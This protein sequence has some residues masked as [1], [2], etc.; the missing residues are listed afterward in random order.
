MDHSLAGTEVT[1]NLKK[2]V[3]NTSEAAAWR[4]CNDSR[5]RQ[6]ILEGTLKAAKGPHGWRIRLAD[7][8]RISELKRRG[9]KP[10]VSYCMRCGKKCPSR[11][12]AGEHCRISG[13]F[14]GAI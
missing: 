7:L 4:G 2:I 11:M 12:A 9:P 10:M 5:I 3:F 6:L 14:T 8:E 1:Q 13:T